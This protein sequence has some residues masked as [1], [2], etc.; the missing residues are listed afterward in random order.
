[1]GLF[2]IGFFRDT[3][4]KFIAFGHK[5]AKLPTTLDSFIAGFGLNE[6]GLAQVGHFSVAYGLVFTS[7]VV[8]WAFNRWWVG[9]ITSFVIGV[10]WVIWKEAYRDTLPPEN[11][12]FWPTKGVPFAQ[13]GLLDALMYWAGIGV[14]TYVAAAVGF[15][16]PH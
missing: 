16:F 8:G 15:A 9:I 12:A 11:A 3:Y 14:A 4:G 2:L 6:N 13:S 7:Y 5:L 1:M 10:P